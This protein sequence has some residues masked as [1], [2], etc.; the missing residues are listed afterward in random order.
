MW[1]DPL[2]RREWLP[3]I[4]L[5]TENFNVRTLLLD[6]EYAVENPEVFVCMF[7]ALTLLV[8]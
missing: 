1:L 2:I 6:Q 4:E 3:N 8:V 7:S 5:M